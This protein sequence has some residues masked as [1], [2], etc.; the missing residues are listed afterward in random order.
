[1]LSPVAVA[2]ASIG[3]DVSLTVGGWNRRLHFETAVL[4]AAWLDECARQA[5][6]AERAT[7]KLLLGHGTLH[8][9]SNHRWLDV[10]QPNDPRHVARVD[11]N[12]LKLASI[13][14]QPQGSL[15]AFSAGSASMMLPWAAAIQ[16]AQWIRLRA[17]ESQMRAGDLTRHW[18]GIVRQHEAAHG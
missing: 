4:L 1:M 6:A 15:V 18:S 5:K 10:G 2:V 11:R 16:V 3:E 17:K 7:S 13:D 8:D 12:L 14:V 9:A